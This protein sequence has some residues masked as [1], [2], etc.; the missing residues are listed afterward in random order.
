MIQVLGLTPSQYGY[1][2]I[3]VALSTMAGGFV[4]ENF[5]LVSHLRKL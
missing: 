1:I 3:F 5:I 2:F 4:S